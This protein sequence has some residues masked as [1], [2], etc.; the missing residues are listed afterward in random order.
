MSAGG[1]VA[2]PTVSQAAGCLRA[3]LS[4]ACC[5]GAR[6]LRGLSEERLPGWAQQQVEQAGWTRG[7]LLCPTPD[8]AA[9]LGTFDFISGATC[10]CRSSPLPAVR[11]VRSRLDELTPAAA[12]PVQRTAAVSGS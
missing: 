9:K 5:R 3:L 4:P 10:D 1:L 2:V 7:R 8:C 11:L 6:E 12:A